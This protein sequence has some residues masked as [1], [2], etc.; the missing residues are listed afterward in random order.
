MRRTIQTM[1]KTTGF[2][3]WMTGMNLTGKTTI[4]EL[5]A[6][7]LSAMGRRVELLDDADYAEILNGGHGE[8]KKERNQLVQ[9]LGQL[10]MVLSR[11]DVIAIVA[12]LSP[13]RD[14]RDQN[15][16]KI[17]RYVEVLVDAPTE[18]L[19]QREINFEREIA[20]INKTEVS[21]GRFHRALAG[22]CSMIGITDPYETSRSPSPTPEIT[23]DTNV[24]TPEACCAQILQ[25]LCE[26]GYF[27]PEE[28]EMVT[29]MKVRK[30][31]KPS[32]APLVPPKPRGPIMLVPKNSPLRTALLQ[33]PGRLPA[34]VRKAL[35][36]NA[37]ELKAEQLAARQ[38][39]LDE[40]KP[41]REE[42]AKAESPK[43]VPPKAEKAEKSAPAKAEKAVKETKETKKSAAES[44]AAAKKAEKAESK[45]AAAKADSKKGVKAAKADVKAA[46][47]KADV[48]KSDAKKTDAKK[49]DAKKA[50]PKKAEVKAAKP[51]KG[52]KA[53]A[54]AKASKKADK[55]AP[56]K[57]AKADAKKAKVAPPTK[58][59]PKKADVKKS[60]AKKAD[61]KKSDAKKAAPK[62]A[63]VK[64]AKPAKGAKA[65]PAKAA[66]ADAKKAK[67]APPKASPK[68]AEVKKAEAKAAKPAKGAKA[69]PSKK[70]K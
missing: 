39:M 69:A 59:S 45:K 21:E 58:A 9:R 68:K 47:K 36:A 32:N 8:N 56:A 27:R 14:A 3:V 5:L 52:A 44:K 22:E 31:I 48:K 41:V 34:E 53:A 66:K 6:A 42:P 65:A 51:A 70:K 50:A 16:Q 33:N 28:I 49:S 60:D 24:N 43:Q 40:M 54:P 11:N 38:A 25:T 17:G 12:A 7:K 1:A 55:A 67:A 57:A 46:A 4:A 23:L 63:E 62:K 15:R 64:A 61:A 29:G 20:R 18:V 26:I 10:A 19:L 2:T 30:F 37:A 35:R 13:Y